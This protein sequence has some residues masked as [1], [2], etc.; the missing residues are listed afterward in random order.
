MTKPITMDNRDVGQPGEPGAEAG[1]LTL[2]TTVN[3]KAYADPAAAQAAATTYNSPDATI[4]RV[5]QA[6]MATD[7]VKAITLQNAVLTQKQHAAK[8]AEEAAN[9]AWRGKL[10]GAMAAG[11]DGL[12]D[13]VTSS[14]AG[15]LAGRKVKAVPTED[16]K[17]VVYNAVGEDGKLT[18][19][20]QFTFANNTDGVTK[21]AFLLDRSITPQ[22]RY[23]ASLKEQELQ[24]KQGD[25][26]EKRQY[27][28][29]LLDSK[30]KQL[31]LTGQIAEA[32]ALAA[33]AKH[34]AN[35][36]PLARE[37]RIRYTTLF[38]DAGRRIKEGNTTLNTLQRDVLFMSKAKKP[39]TPEAQQLAGLQEELTSHKQERELYQG[40]LA[41]SQGD[42]KPEAKKPSLA[43][44][45]APAGPVKVSTKAERD[46]LPAGTRYVGPDGAT[47]VKQ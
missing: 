18:P 44:A 40:L 32:K 13:L 11:H 4:S 35:G 28:Q 20:P 22:Q 9:K 17:S 16:G 23:E 1:G 29:G 6:Q 33:A 38:T 31:E 30:I 8:Q 5:A 27:H 2:G 42:A 34:S 43:D 36:G 46:K 45:K 41:G 12:A 15:P 47:Y 26:D 37:E 25:S 21:A 39:G 7:P 24:R 10:G 3:G 19:L 14:E